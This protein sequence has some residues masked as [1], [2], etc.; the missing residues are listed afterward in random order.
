[1]FTQ[2]NDSLR[3]VGQ[4]SFQPGW[5]GKGRG[6]DR[7]DERCLSSSEAAFPVDLRCRLADGLLEAGIHLEGTRSV[8]RKPGRKV[9]GRLDIDPDTNPE[10]TDDDFL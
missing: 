9:F 7:R 1:M 10:G 8:P 5:V 3:E 4:E 6:I 2:E